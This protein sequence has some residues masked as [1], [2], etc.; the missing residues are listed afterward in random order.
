MTQNQETESQ[1]AK[2]DD[3]TNSGLCFYV[4]DLRLRNHENQGD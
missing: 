3:K 4:N 1:L 2:H